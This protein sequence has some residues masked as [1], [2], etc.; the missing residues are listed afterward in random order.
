ML[1]SYNNLLFWSIFMHCMHHLIST[2]FFSSSS[3][4]VHWSAEI[5]TKFYDPRKEGV[6]DQPT[7]WP[8][9]WIRARSLNSYFAF[10]KIVV[11]VVQ[12]QVNQHNFTKIAQSFHLFITTPTPTPSQSK[13]P[14]N[15]VQ[16]YSKSGDMGRRGW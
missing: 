5:E 13:F 8:S 7:D 14:L 2:T 16:E 6:T 10:C 4:V 15:P 11:K 3:Q 1:P 12:C 9:E